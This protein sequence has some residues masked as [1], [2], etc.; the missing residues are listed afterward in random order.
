MGEIHSWTELERLIARR[1]TKTGSLYNINCDKMAL[2]GKLC[3]VN[4]VLWRGE[5]L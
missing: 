3:R 2:K 1:E 4:G 5:L